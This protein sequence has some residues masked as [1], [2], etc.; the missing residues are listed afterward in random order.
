MLASGIASGLACCAMI[1]RDLSLAGRFGL[2]TSVDSYVIAYTFLM[3]LSS[4][5]AGSV[6]PAL[7]PAFVRLRTAGDPA[8]ACWLA[9]RAAVHICGV[10]AAGAVLIALFAIPV[11]GL[12]ASNFSDQGLRL[13]R[14]VM[15]WMAGMLPLQGVVAVLTVMAQARGSF[16][17][18]GLAPALP[19]L[20]AALC[21]VCCGRQY[22]IDAAAAGTLAGVF[23]QLALFPVEWRSLLGLGVRARPADGAHVWSDTVRQYWPVVASGVLMSATPL[24][25]QAMAA[26][27][28]VGSVSL[29]S[30]GQKL[31]SLMITVCSLAVSNAVLPHFSE[32][33][34]RNDWEG[35]RRSVRVMGRWIWAVSVPVT[36]ILILFSN[37]IAALVFKRGAVSAAD[38]LNIGAV[39]ALL[40]LQLPFY[41]I[42]I[43][44]VRLI[45]SLKAN[46][47]L[48]YGT[49][50]SLVLKLVFNFVLMRWW[51]VRGIALATS[52][53]YV[54]ACIFLLTAGRVTLRRQAESARLRAVSRPA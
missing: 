14:M 46:V 9:R 53:V 47:V 37:P 35:L 15:L 13:G 21:L 39:Q 16:L 31:A 44:S 33:S 11:L 18:S 45:S 49:I 54:V 17:R 43:L 7:L 29:L 36:G 34:S 4:V 27:Q 3:F 1:I 40:L 10:M 26:T 22:G 38:A 32:M 41:M 50:L 2:G 12:I 19:P 52:L 42:G 25:D 24:I 48:M 51:G 5:M 6:N 20:G 28:A 30:Y 23:L 8:A